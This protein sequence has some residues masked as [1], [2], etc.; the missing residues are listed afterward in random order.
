VVAGRGA[1]RVAIVTG[2]GGGVGRAAAQKLLDAGCHVA[3]VGRTEAT[4]E[5]AAKDLAWGDAQVE[6]VVGDVAQRASF[7]HAVDRVKRTLGPISIL[8]HAAGVAE[9]SPLLPPDDAVFDRAYAVN[10]K[11]AWIA[12]TACLPDMVAAKWGRVVHVGSVAGLRGFRYVAGYVASKHALVGLVRALAL[13]LEGR[14]VTVNAVCPGFLDTPMTERSIDKIVAA[15]GRTRD[16]ALADLLASAGQAELI[17][18]DEVAAAIVSLCRD[19]AS[20]V[21]GTA[22]AL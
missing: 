12:T 11:G 21:T 2:G 6:T 10:V 4:L 8:V 13:D 19:E 1:G 7:E 22:V 18:P 15:T 3:L 20:D 14:G 16:G 17:P 9:A 5:K